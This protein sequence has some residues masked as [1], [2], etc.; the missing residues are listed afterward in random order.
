MPK[1]KQGQFKPS[2]PEKYKGDVNNI[3]YRSSWELKT[4]SILDRNPNVIEWSSEEII[5]PYIS[6]KD[7]KIHRYFVD[8]FCKLKNKNGIIETLLIE[9]KPLVQTSPPIKGKRI[10]KGFINEV[11]TYAVND[12]KWKAAQDYCD[13][14]GWKFKIF[15]EK[16]LGIKI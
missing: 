2:K 1:Y 6:P 11:L 9:I 3:F 14:R 10:T 15:T 13:K 5:I 7:N 4:F 12:A 16:E 8:I